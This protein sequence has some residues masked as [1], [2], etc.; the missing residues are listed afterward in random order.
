M[1]LTIIT[2]RGWD[3]T[4]RGKNKKRTIISGAVSIAIFVRFLLDK[5]SFC[6]RLFF[7]YVW[8]QLSD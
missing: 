2:E 7:I 3:I 6:P 5:N 4:K 1:W 8:N